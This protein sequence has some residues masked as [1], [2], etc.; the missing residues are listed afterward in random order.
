MYV[1]VCITVQTMWIPVSERVRLWWW[2]NLKCVCVQY[3]TAIN[4]V[5]WWWYRLDGLWYTLSKSTYYTSKTE[6]PQDTS[7]GNNIMNYFTTTTLLTKTT[8]WHKLLYTHIGY[9][10]RQGSVGLHYRTCSNC[11]NY[12]WFFITTALLR[13]TYHRNDS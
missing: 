6:W 2:N 5:G 13:L 11:N 3:G 10:V 1:L 9:N 8:S 12:N 7:L 4:R